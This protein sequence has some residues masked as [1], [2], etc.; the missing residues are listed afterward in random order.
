M[1]V[2]KG[3]ACNCSLRVSEAQNS[4]RENSAIKRSLNLDRIANPKPLPLSMSLENPST[5]PNSTHGPTLNLP[6]VNLYRQPSPSQLP[7]IPVIPVLFG[8]RGLKMKPCWPLLALPWLCPLRL[9]QSKKL[10]G[11]CPCAAKGTL[12]EQTL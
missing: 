2:D 5:A 11:R 7:Y 4:A 9:S 8:S 3:T 6:S 12:K 1:R 10:T